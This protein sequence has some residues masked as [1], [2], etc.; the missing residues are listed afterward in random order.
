MRIEH[1]DGRLT[2]DSLRSGSACEVY[3]ALAIRHEVFAE[4]GHRRVEGQ[5]LRGARGTRD[6]GAN[7]REQR[8][9]TQQ[10]NY[11][12]C[13]H[14]NA[15]RR[16]A[17]RASDVISASLY[18]GCEIHLPVLHVTNLLHIGTGVRLYSNLQM[19]RDAAQVE[20]VRFCRM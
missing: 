10:W 16:I 9:R 6:R 2:R 12:A 7:K 19:V 20:V 8:K 15:F 18:G 4:R 5:R 3:F 11:G 17:Y 14:D 13:S 1:H